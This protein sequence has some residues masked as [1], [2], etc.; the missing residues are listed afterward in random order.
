MLQIDREILLWINGHHAEWLDTLLLT[1]T[2]KRTW[3]VLY[4]ALIVCFIYLY[5]GSR[6]AQKEK[7]SWRRWVPCV[8]AIVAVAAAAGLADW[9]TSGLI[10]PLVLRERPCNEPLL[11]GLLRSVRGYTAG[12][13]SFPSSHAA[14]TMAVA[15]SAW[16]VFKQSHIARPWWRLWQVVLVLYVALNIYS[17]MYL[18]V[19]YPTDILVGLVCGGVIGW[20]TAFAFTKIHDFEEDSSHNDGA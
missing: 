11:Y 12:G 7:K 1:A 17:R 15:T 5:R 10:K 18:G 16:L 3:I 20:G 4:I 2:E 14:D 9:F 6:Y 8:C 19:H 13:Y